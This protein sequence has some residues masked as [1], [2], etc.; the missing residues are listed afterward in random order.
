MHMV[1]RILVFRGVAIG[2]W[3]RKC[4][5]T[6]IFVERKSFCVIH[7][8]LYVW[9]SLCRMEFYIFKVLFLL[10]WR[11]IWLH[12][13]FYHFVVSQS[14]E[15]WAGIFSDSFFRDQG[16]W[17]YCPCSLQRNNWGELIWIWMLAKLTIPLLLDL[18]IICY[19]YNKN[20]IVVIINLKL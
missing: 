15:Q 6:V 11:K 20:L 9:S 18:Y 4:T 19:N 17:A 16:L 13:I 12:C 5:Y 8:F 7:I 14:T 2:C 10:G 1:S 3:I